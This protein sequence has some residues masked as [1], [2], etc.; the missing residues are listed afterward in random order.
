[1]RGYWKS[2]DLTFFSDDDPQHGWQQTYDRYR[3]R[4]QAD[5]K[6]M[7]TLKFEQLRVDPTG[8]KSALVRGHWQLTFQD[9]KTRGGLFTLLFREESQGWCIVHDHT[10]AKPRPR[11]ALLCRGGARVGNHAALMRPLDDSTPRR[12]QRVEPVPSS[13]RGYPWAGFLVVAAAVVL[14]AVD[15]PPLRRRLERRQPAGH[16]R[17]AR[18]SA[19]AGHRR[20]DL[21]P[22]P[23]RR[24]GASRRTR[25]TTRSFSGAPSTSCTSTDT[26]TRTSRRCRRC[27][28]PA[29]TRRGRR[30]PG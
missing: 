2:D 27:F 6:E 14:A 5:G 18:R 15:R 19:H 9:G 20:F 28:W 25:R 24:A 10:S 4:Y 21:R 12:A 7:G 17:G 3:A 13:G 29:F 23:P 26:T 30:R 22:H 16:R 11:F 1:M 8:P